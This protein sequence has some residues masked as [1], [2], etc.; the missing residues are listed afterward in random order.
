MPVDE[1]CD[2]SSGCGTPG[3][4]DD[5][6]MNGAS[7]AALKFAVEA[8]EVLGEAPDPAWAEIANKLLIPRGTL[9]TPLGIYKD[10]HLMPN[11]TGPFVRNASHLVTARC[12]HTAW[13]LQQLSSECNVI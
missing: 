10:V 12:T 5:P 2:Q 1:W 8:A 6:Q 9:T 11:G 3:V 13:E 7:V 4:N